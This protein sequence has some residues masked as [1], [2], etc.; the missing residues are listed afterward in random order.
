MPSAAAPGR[1]RRSGVML[2]E[3]PSDEELAR[4]WTLSESDKSEVLQCRGEEKRRWFAL[5][6]CVLRGYGR[7][8]EPGETAPVR[9]VNHLGAQLELPPVL[10]VSGIQRAATES[11]YA[12]RIRRYLGFVRFHRRLQQEIAEWVRDRTLQGLSVEEV[13]QQAERWL[14]ERC[15]VLPRAAVFARLVAAQCR[16]AERG[17]YAM[18]AQQA[19]PALLPELDAL[20]EVP[21]SSNRS[22]LF[23]LKEYPPEGKPDTI[24]VF[25][26]N[27]TWLKAI[28]VGEIRIAGCH[29]ALIRQLAWAVRLGRLA[30]ARI[31]G[32]KTPR[33]ARMFCHRCPEDHSRSCR[34]HERSVL[35]RDVPPIAARLRARVV[36]RQKTGPA[37]KRAGPAGHGDCA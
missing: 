12:E 8:L 1:A 16:R 6:L 35:D 31:S 36:R 9:I 33:P 23:R 26:E 14:R 19:P 22:H 18:L 30:P 13:T 28:G 7:F 4:N 3:D 15:V 37:G 34:R 29:P 25:L 24:L 11:E 2:P 27:Y 5:Q 20:L 17:L 10:L 21:E 32:G